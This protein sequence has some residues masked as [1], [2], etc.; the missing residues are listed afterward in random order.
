[1]NSAIKLIHVLNIFI[2]FIL[3]FKFTQINEFM[4]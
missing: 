4:Y 1:M 3:I 2:E